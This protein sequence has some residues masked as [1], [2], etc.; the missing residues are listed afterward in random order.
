MIEVESYL[1]SGDGQFTRVDDVH[2]APANPS[3]VEGA[4]VL[5]IDGVTILDT[6]LWDDVDEL[7]A[8]ISEMVGSLGEKDEVSTYFPDQPI[9]LT[10]RRQGNKRILVSL[11]RR[12]G[13]RAANASESEL[14]SSLQA[15]GTHFFARMSELL[16]ENRGAYDDAVAR[17]MSY[18]R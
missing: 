1:R 3:H 8:Y 18:Q 11:D 4:L 14:V 9:K 5:R 12:K 17:L 13:N 15:E 10:F 6:A 7:W 2:D 16:P